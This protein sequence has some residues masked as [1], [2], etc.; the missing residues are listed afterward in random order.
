MS[1]ALHGFSPRS[2]DDSCFGSPAR[3][4]YTMLNTLFET[5]ARGN[6]GGHCGETAKV[7]ARLPDCTYEHYFIEVDLVARMTIDRVVPRLLLPL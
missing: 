1:A 3:A 6:A 7:V 4:N 2:C 5:I